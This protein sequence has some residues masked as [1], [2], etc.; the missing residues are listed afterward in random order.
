MSEIK[1]LPPVKTFDVVEQVDHNPDGAVPTQWS[2]FIIRDDGLIKVPGMDTWFTKDNLK[3]Y[4][5]FCSRAV[6]VLPILLAVML[7]TGCFS[8]RW[9]DMPWTSKGTIINSTTLSKSAGPPMPEVQASVVVTRQP[10]AY[11]TFTNGCAW[12]NFTN[13]PHAGLVVGP[14]CQEPKT[15]VTISTIPPSN[16]Y[17]FASPTLDG[18]GYS[19]GLI[20]GDM[21]QPLSTTNTFFRLQQNLV[22]ILDFGT[23]L[24]SFTG[25]VTV[26]ASQAS[27]TGLK[28]GALYYFK[29]EIKDDAGMVS[30]ASQ[31]V[32]WTANTNTVTLAWNPPAPVMLKIR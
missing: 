26:A 5:E 3:K 20:Q 22:G 32:S 27:V 16:G 19:L 14:F 31:V 15:N 2:Q 6:D 17:L 12:V 18:T 21:V 13:G 1:V 29:A 8:D 28:I 10:T 7:L 23:S 9:G 30:L 24:N 4:F 11:E 25:Q